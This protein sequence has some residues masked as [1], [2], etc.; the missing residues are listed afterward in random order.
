MYR[1]TSYNSCITKHSTSVT[2]CVHADDDGLELWTDADDGEALTADI[3]ELLSYD[4]N[5]ELIYITDDVLLDGEDNADEEMEL[6]F[7]DSSPTLTAGGTDDGGE[8]GWDV[9][10]DAQR[11]LGKSGDH[12][13]RQSPEG[14]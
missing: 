3:D 8:V 6:V 4:V 1:P 7:R 13:D 5:S 2:T 10:R 11:D 9:D 12:Q 14:E